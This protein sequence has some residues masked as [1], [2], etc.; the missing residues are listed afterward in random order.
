ML[1]AMPD[2]DND[3]PVDPDSDF[4]AKYVITCARLGVT[5]VS[6]ERAADLIRQFTDAINRNAEP[7][8]TG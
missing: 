8:T 7:P 3:G 1:A 5:P 6:V 4:F 2:A